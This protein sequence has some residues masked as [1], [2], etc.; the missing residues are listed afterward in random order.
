MKTDCLGSNPNSANPSP[1]NCRPVTDIPVP[2]S[3]HLLEVT[4][5]SNSGGCCFIQ[6]VNPCEEFENVSSTWY[7][8]NNS[9]LFPGSILAANMGCIKALKIWPTTSILIL[10]PFPSPPS[11]T[12]KLALCLTSPPTPCSC[13]LAH[14]VPAA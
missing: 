12:P 8:V 9:L 6:Q 11:A 7:T 14:A 13:A 1:Y 2:H 5:A 3:P 10:S 4:E